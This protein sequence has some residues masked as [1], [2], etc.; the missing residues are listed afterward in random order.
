MVSNGSGCPAGTALVRTFVR[1]DTVSGG[2]VTDVTN[3]A[4]DAGFSFIIP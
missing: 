2:N 1:S 4:S 3:T